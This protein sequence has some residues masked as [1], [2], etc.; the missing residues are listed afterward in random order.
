M[1]AITD[2]FQLSELPLLLAFFAGFLFFNAPTLRSFLAPLFSRS[3]ERQ[4]LA[5]KQLSAHFASG[6]YEAVVHLFEASAGAFAPEAAGCYIASLSALGRPVAAALRAMQLSPATQLA[7]VEQL[8]GSAAVRV[9]VLMQEQGPLCPAAGE[10]LARAAEAALPEVIAMGVGV[11]AYRDLVE[12]AL[13]SHKWRLAVDLLKAMARH[14]QYVPAHVRTAVVRETVMHDLPAA[15]ALFGIVRLSGEALTAALC[16]AE[17]EA[18]ELGACPSLEALV[19][20]AAEQ[21]LPMLYSSYE[22][23]LKAW[24]RLGDSR[25]VGCFQDM[26][27]SGFEPTEGTCLAVLEGCP[28]TLARAVLAFVTTSGKMTP[29]L[30]AAA[31]KL[32]PKKKGRPMQAFM[33][34]VKECA[35]AKDVEKALKLL[36]EQRE[37][38]RVDVIACNAVLSVCVKAGSASAAR[39]LIR[40]MRRWQMVDAASFNTMLGV[41]HPLPTVEQVNGLLAEMQAAGVEPTT[42]TYNTAINVAVSQGAVAAAWQYVAAM[43]AAGLSL[44]AFTCTTLLK[45][46]RQ[47]RRPADVD[48]ILALLESRHIAADGVLVA[49]L[50]EACVRL[51]DEKRVGS[52]LAKVQEVGI[53]PN[54]HAYATVLRAYAQLATPLEAKRAAV[55]EVWAAAVAKG[56]QPMEVVQGAYVECQAAMGDVGGAAA[57]LTALPSPPPSAYASVIRALAATDMPKA[58]QL[59][60]RLR[61]EKVQLHLVTYNA[62]IDACSR[63]G[64]VEEMATLF[65]DLCEQGL[66]PDV[67]T[68]STVIK[69]YAVQGDLEHAIALFTLMRKR[70]IRPD[71]ILFNSILDGCA[72]QGKRQLAEQVFAD[73]GSMQLLVTNHTLSILVKLYGR[74][75]DAEE[76]IRVVETL[77]GKHGFKVNTTVLTC[78]MKTCLDNGLVVKARELFASLEEPDLKAVQTCVQGCLRQRNVSAAVACLEEAA[79]Q[80]LHDPRLVADVKR[81]QRRRA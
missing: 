50:L 27:R 20:V 63:V 31:A 2:V 8:R 12:E 81:A 66:V 59:Y 56:V 77:P 60:K 58:M 19:R 33:K 17:A 54:G 69:G 71:A 53:L 51:K 6:N 73:M 46:T 61:G 79:R 68:Y 14:S 26:L 34:A 18:R 13:A 70:G 28:P 57:L 62:L 36:E 10:A 29:A 16:A 55:E 80:G 78:L 11:G 25:A 48:R 3:A 24:A 7:I 74:C 44:D 4:K 43:D 15:V 35:A 45:S 75:H 72:R 38:G 23:L 39:G 49:G 41:K 32:A 37:T 21:K 5:G 64:N 40:D 76:A 65:R 9:A 42:V 22:A 47:L 67:V 1:V 30:R 52:A